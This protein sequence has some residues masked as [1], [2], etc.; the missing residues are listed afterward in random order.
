MNQRGSLASPVH[1]VPVD[2]AKINNDKHIVARITR[3]IPV[4]F[5]GC[6]AKQNMALS[7]P[8]RYLAMESKN[9]IARPGRDV[10][11]ARSC[12]DCSARIGMSDPSVLLIL[13]QKTAPYLLSSVNDV[14]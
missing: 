1:L 9:S 10:N 2:S 5:V 14:F 7:N 12:Q 3:L 13:T 11:W 8:G 6:Q 4:I